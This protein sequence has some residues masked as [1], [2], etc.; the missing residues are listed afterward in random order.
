MKNGDA[1][2]VTKADGS[3][4]N[5]RATWGRYPVDILDVP[6]EEGKHVKFLTGFLAPCGVVYTAAE[7]AEEVFYGH[8]VDHHG[9]FVGHVDQEGLLDY[10]CM[11]EQLLATGELRP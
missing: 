1:I 6:V 4:K 10:P 8:P 7:L 9:E 5:G 2:T 3:T 11:A